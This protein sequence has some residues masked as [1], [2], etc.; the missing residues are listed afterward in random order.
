LPLKTSYWL[1]VLLHYRQLNTLSLRV[2]LVAV[3]VEGA[4]DLVVA[5]VALVGIELL[6]DLQFPLAFLLLSQWVQAAAGERKGQ[7]PHLVLS[8]QVVAALVA[9]LVVIQLLQPLE[10]LVVVAVLVVAQRVLLVTLVDIPQ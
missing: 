10:A 7:R 6:L 2:V 5:V 1:V 4:L 8:H 3:L 9:A